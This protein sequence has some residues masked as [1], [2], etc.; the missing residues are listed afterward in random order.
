AARD[1][2]P[3]DAQ[4]PD[5]PAWQRDPPTQHERRTDLAIAASLFVLAILSM[6]LGRAAQQFP[7]PAPPWLAV[8]LLAAVTLPLAWRR[9]WPSSVAGVAAAA[10]IAAG[11]AQVPETVITN[12]ALFVAL[13]TVGAWEGSRRRAMVVRL[14]IIDVMVIWLVI[15]FFRVATDQDG[16]DG[17]AVAGALT[18]FAAN[19]LIQVMINI[20]YFA[21]AY[22]FGD[23][24]WR[25][26]RERARTARRTEELQAERAVVAAQA[27]TIERM[28]LARE[29]HD[30]VAHHVSLMG[31]QAAAAR[32]VL[33]RDPRAAAQALEQV[34]EAAR[35]AVTE[36]RGLLGTLR[37]DEAG[38][39]PV[40]S[41]GVESIPELVA[42]TE[43]AGTPTSYLVVGEPQPLPPVLSLNLYRIAQ[44]AL[45]NVRKHA[46]K[47]AEA[48]VRVRYSPDAVEL[49]I[50]DDG[51]SGRP[52]GPADG[53][54]SGLGLVG[55]T[56]R[57]SSDG[58][59]LHTGPSR[60]GGFLVRVH[61]PLQTPSQQ[62]S[63]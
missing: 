7:E 42:D 24:A 31:V 2:P 30:A 21:G 6:V 44:E 41:L 27:V 36:M 26:A 13:Y 12:I 3:L 1:A 48:D 58:G 56:E 43:A 63:E 17:E 29:L 14:A 45:T 23:H 55:M 37:E 39:A 59:T 35:D 28:R 60:K 40:A 9:V 57:A 32:T 34:E 61:V 8:L 22:W 19:M 51:G 53:P 33:D 10:F 11:E 38:S 54:A 15:T 25:G 4:D 47:D 16:T 18:P 46:G 50:A 49:E 20:L 62:E 52:R 5:S